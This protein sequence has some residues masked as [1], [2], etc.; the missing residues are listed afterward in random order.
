MLLVRYFG[1]VH[2]DGGDEDGW[3]TD[4]EA[5]SGGVSVARSREDAMQY[6]AGREERSSISGTSD[7]AS[8]SFP[9]HLIFLQSSVVAKPKSAPLK[10]INK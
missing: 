3:D 8:F 1:L 10:Q 2:P 7:N 4:V 9:T 5:A 6:Y